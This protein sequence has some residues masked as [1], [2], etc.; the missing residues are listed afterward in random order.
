[1]LNYDEYILNKLQKLQNRGMP[2]ILSVNRY[3]KLESILDTLG[4]LSVRHKIVFNS[5]LFIHKII[6]NLLPKYLITKFEFNEPHYTT[7]QTTSLRIEKTRTLS[8]EKSIVYRGAS[9]Y[10]K[11]PHEIIIED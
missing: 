11:L 7:R 3:T 5:C 1:M 8:A 10:N 6:N 9:W 4:W 2:V